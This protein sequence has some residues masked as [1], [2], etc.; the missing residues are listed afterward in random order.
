LEFTPYLQESDAFSLTNFP[1]TIIETTYLKEYT[2]T[3]QITSNTSSKYKFKIRGFDG[4]LGDIYIDN[5]M[6]ELVGEALNIPKKW[7]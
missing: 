4:A 5:V 7:Y 3:T 1:K 2:L 6:I